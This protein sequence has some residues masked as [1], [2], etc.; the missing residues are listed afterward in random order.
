MPVAGAGMARHF[1]FFSNWGGPSEV[2][3]SSLQHS[4]PHL[5]TSSAGMP[6]FH[7]YVS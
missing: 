4:S 2:N 5:P 6:L 1:F 3:C 7:M